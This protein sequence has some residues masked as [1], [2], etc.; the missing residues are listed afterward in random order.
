MGPR[1]GSGS[2][3]LACRA[4]QVVLPAALG[5]S[6]TTITVPILPHVTGPVASTGPG[7]ESDGVGDDA[8]HYQ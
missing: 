6:T 3:L 7:R 8:D 2:Q 4:H 5:P 1:P